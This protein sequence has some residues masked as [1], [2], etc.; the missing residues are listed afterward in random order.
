LRDSRQL[1]LASTANLVAE[2]IKKEELNRLTEEIPDFKCDV[3]SALAE[4]HRR[5]AR[6][7]G[8]W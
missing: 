5:P 8:G 2:N 1:L 6:T 7:L 4:Q 3:F